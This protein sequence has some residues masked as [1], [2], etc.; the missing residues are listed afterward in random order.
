DAAAEGGVVGLARRLGIV[1]AGANQGEGIVTAAEWSNL[2]LRG[3]RFVVMSACE[4]GLGEIRNGDGVHG[5]RR[6]LV[7][8][9]TQ[10]QVL[11]LWR[12]DDA[13]TALLIQRMYERLAAGANVGDALHAARM[14]LARDGRFRHPRYWAAFTVSGRSVVRV[15]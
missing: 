10:A 5:L 13:A 15:R 14:S 1:F 11:S 3:T 2:D 8:A 12:V 9:G 4:S 7:L 6:A